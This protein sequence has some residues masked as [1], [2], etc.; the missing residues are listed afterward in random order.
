MGIWEEGWDEKLPEEP[1]GK[2]SPWIC[3]DCS[4]PSPELRADGSPVF[5]LLRMIPYRPPEQ[6]LSSFPFSY[7]W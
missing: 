3:W 2:H 7:L 5:A 4:R 1:T 6:T